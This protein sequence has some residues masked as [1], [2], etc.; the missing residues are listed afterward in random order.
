MGDTRGGTVAVLD[1][2]RRALKCAHQ[3]D[4]ARQ[5]AYRDVR[6]DLSRSTS[7][8]AR[9][10]TRS[11]AS[12]SSIARGS[13]SFNIVCSELAN[14]SA[15]S[16]RMKTPGQSL[17]NCIRPVSTLRVSTIFRSTP[18]AAAILAFQVSP[19][20]RRQASLKACGSYLVARLLAVD[21]RDGYLQ[22]IAERLGALPQI[23][24]SDVRSAVAT[25]QR[26]YFTP[27][28][29]G[30]SIGASAHRGDRARGISGSPRYWTDFGP[31]RFG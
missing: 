15:S 27:P 3:A 14:D 11:S 9:D 21:D 31:G 13:T 10:H 25:A 16:P 1:P 22:L 8:L 30:R 6:H 29:A 24:N 23:G 7:S 18:L 26:A 2:E 4:R 17:P 28:L 5:P 20:R 12:D 19:V